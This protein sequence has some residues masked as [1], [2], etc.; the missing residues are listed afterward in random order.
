MEQ[1]NVVAA[2]HDFDAFWGESQVAELAG[3]DFG[4]EQSAFDD[5]VEN[6]ND[7]EGILFQYALSDAEVLDQLP[8]C[9]QLGVTR[10]GRVQLT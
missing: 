4:V 3:I 7:S 8:R 1:K 9:R 10:F 2:E 6:C 5:L